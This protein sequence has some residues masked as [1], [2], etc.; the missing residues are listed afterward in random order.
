[1]TEKPSAWLEQSFANDIKLVG[2]IPV[3]D[4]HLRAGLFVGCFQLKIFCV[5]D[6]L[7][8]QDAYVPTDEKSTQDGLTTVQ[9]KKHKWLSGMHSIN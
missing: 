9:R 6:V 5:Q 8:V 4:I 2:L 3:W 7:S 1:M